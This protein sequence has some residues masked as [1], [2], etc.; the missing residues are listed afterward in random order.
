MNKLEEKYWLLIGYAEGMAEALAINTKCSWCKSAS[1]SA[2]KIADELKKI[3]AEDKAAGRQ[4]NR[5]FW[6]GN[7][8]VTSQELKDILFLEQQKTCGQ[9]EDEKQ[10]E[11]IEVLKLLAAI[12]GMQCL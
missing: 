2:K 11:I 4:E 7:I 6:T 9:A 12:K 3:A 1:E 5:L 8:M 10:E